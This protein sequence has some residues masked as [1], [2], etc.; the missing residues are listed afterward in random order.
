MDQLLVSPADAARKLGIG[1]T[2]LYE[3][4]ASGRLPSIKL[5]RRRLIATASLD[6]FVEH[7]AGAAESSSQR[8]A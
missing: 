3:L 8:V 4:I 6:N 7:L 1:R 2:L 5:G